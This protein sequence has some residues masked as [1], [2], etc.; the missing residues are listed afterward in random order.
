MTSLVL[1]GA[2]LGLVLA[3]QVGPVT[4]LIVRSVLRG[5]RALAVGVAM[6]VAV[7]SVDVLYAALGLAGAGTVLDAPAAEL[8]L[9]LASAAILIAIGLRT[10]LAGIHAR[11]GLETTADVVSPRRAFATALAATAFN[12]LT[13]ALWTISFPAAAPHVAEGSV[14]AGAALLAGIAVGTLAWY[15]G[16]S[17]AVAL[18][19]RRLGD[20]LLV[21]VDLV[22]GLG[23]VAFGG[24]LG[25][26][27]LERE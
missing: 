12:P 11:V 17:A 5:G 13:I 2:G 14:R 21:A 25:Y 19:R 9:G 23:M 6:A 27:T 1:A 7:A 20:T 4:L 16:F 26:R 22:A 18:A 8:V 3:A 10:L 24:L 15:C